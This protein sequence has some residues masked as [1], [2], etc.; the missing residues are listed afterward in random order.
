MLAVVLIPGLQN[1]HVVKSASITVL[2]NN[3]QYYV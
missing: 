1:D 3:V 2:I